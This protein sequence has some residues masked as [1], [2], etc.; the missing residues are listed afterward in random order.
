MNETFDCTRRYLTYDRDDVEV[1]V[2]L[3]S[4]SDALDEE[5]RL[6]ARLRP[7]DNLLGQPELEE[8]PF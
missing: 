7:R 1:A 5:M 6:I 3:T 2:R 8:A 4:P